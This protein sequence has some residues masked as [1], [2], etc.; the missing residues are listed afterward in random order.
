[1]LPLL[2]VVGAGEHVG[3]DERGDVQ[4]PLR[5][6]LLL[7]G[8]P[9]ELPRRHRVAGEDHRGH[10]GL[11][12][13]G[14]GVGGR[15]L[16]RG[17]V[18]GVRDVLD[19]L[20]AGLLERVDR[21]LRVGGRRRD[22]RSRCGG[23]ANVRSL[24]WNSGSPAN[25]AG[26]PA[27]CLE[28][29]STLWARACS[30]VRPRPMPYGARS[31]RSSWLPPAH[32]MH[33]MPRAASSSPNASVRAGPPNTMEGLDVLGDL[34]RVGPGGG[35]VGGQALAHVV[36]DLDRAAV[37][38]VVGLQQVDQLVL[39]CPCA[40]GVGV[41]HRDRVGDVL[42]HRVVLGSQVRDD[43]DG[44]GGDAVVG[45]AAVVALEREVARRRAAR[46]DRRAVPSSVS[47]RSPHSSSSV[48][49]AASPSAQLNG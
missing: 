46:R 29:T 1:M 13:L 14:D 4:E 39:R 35:G 47:H 36:L 3:V 16:E 45:G 10:A 27:T 32:P 6:V 30:V 40:V 48:S 11:L 28:S 22:R 24:S 33:W 5:E 20:D 38:L 15:L 23:S 42:D 8:L 49:P 9:G 25:S 43:L 34:H 44:V 18:E 7:G 2:L 17:R 26:R 21:V 31:S 37:G 12:Q 41:V 19:D